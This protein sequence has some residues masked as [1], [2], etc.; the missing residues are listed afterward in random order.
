MSGRLHGTSEQSG[1]QLLLI[2]PNSLV[3]NL[4][5]QV[6]KDLGLAQVHQTSNWKTAHQWM[7]ERSMDAL[8][9]TG[10]ELQHTEELLT[11]VRMSQFRCS[12]DVQVIGLVATGDE[13]TRT[14]LRALNVEQFINVPF[15]IREVVDALYALWPAALHERLTGGR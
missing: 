10:D 12:P 2:E 6:M 15:K 5:A 7:A 14:R 3:R 1:Y 4:I 8:I 13:R 9:V 11:L